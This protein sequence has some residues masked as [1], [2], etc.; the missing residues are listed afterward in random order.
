[1]KK[2]LKKISLKKRSLGKKITLIALS[3]CTVTCL[4]M[5][6]TVYA[7]ENRNLIKTTKKRVENMAESIAKNIDGNLHKEIVEKGEI[8]EQYNNYCNQLASFV[9]EESFQYL[10]T[11]VKDSEGN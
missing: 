4:I 6:G 10:Y 3:L 2:M 8:S 11:I 5:G 9:E 7:F 1:M